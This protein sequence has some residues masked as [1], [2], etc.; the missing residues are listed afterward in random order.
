MS[1]K[2]YIIA[3]AGVN[4]NGSLD[5]AL[6]MVDVAAEAGA[7]AVKFQT[8]VAEEVVSTHAPK[9]RYQEETTGSVESQLE[10]VRKLDFA[11]RDQAHLA[12]LKRAGQ[13]GI[14]FL[15]TPFDLKSL[16]FLTG[17]LGLRKIKIASG[18]VT[19]GPLLLAAARADC[20][21]ILS[22]GM[23]D[24][25]EIKTALGVL[26]YGSRPL[27]EKPS[28]EAFARAY[29]DDAARAILKK[30]V[31]L[32]HCVTAYPAPANETNLRAIGT[33]AEM[34]GLRTGFSDHSLGTSVAIAAAARGA[35]MLEKH[36][37]LD[38]NQPGPDHAASLEPSELKS[39]V[40]AVREVEGILG[41]GIKEPQPCER[42]NMP[43]ARRS[44][45]ARRPIKAGAVI[46]EDDLA[47]KRPA[48]GLSPMRYWDIVGQRA[49]K[50]YDADEPI[51]Q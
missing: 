39:L 14:E 10:M 1:N 40:N 36:F 3:E 9:A 30:R 5:A 48:G 17:K 27:N 7:D 24:L 19:N 49:V 44:L 25:G 51:A 45:V 28:A 47:V 50:D 46:G 32:M 33:L 15:S 21:L 2:V 11:D 34:F 4:H 12:L 41:S 31:S 13:R 37:T 8:F 35:V 29:Q 42:E 16:A 6:K 22:T 26:A 43:I 38:R 20:D 23:A 18:E